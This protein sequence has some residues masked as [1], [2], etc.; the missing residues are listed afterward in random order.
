MRRVVEQDL[1]RLA[2]HFRGQDRSRAAG[3]GAPID[4][5]EAGPLGPL[6]PET[7]P[8]WWPNKAQRKRL[9]G[10]RSKATPRLVVA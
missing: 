8:P 5:S 7:A 1:Q 2:T 6:W 3:L 9:R 4:P 10:P